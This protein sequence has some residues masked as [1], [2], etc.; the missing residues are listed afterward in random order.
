MEGFVVTF[1]VGGTIFKTTTTT[2]N[3]VP[4]AETTLLCMLLRRRLEEEV[5]FIDKDPVL[6]RWILQW[7][8]HGGR[9]PPAHHTTVGIS[10]EEWSA[11]MDYYGI[12]GEQNVKK[13]PRDEESEIT[14][15]LVKKANQVAEKREEELDK[16]RLEKIRLFAAVIS[17]ML[18]NFNVRATAT[19]YTFASYDQVEYPDSY[20]VE[21]RHD[22]RW[23]THWWKD[24]QDYISNLGYTAKLDI[25]PRKEKYPHFESYRFLPAS[26]LPPLPTG[27]IMCE[28]SISVNK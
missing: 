4:G 14:A 25:Y 23:V 27:H 3:S 21:I 15:S 26:F 24:F 2:L 28:I 8:R 17:Y 6:F 11:E 12:G 16:V 13:R 20:P 7:Y 5:I 18:D 22:F 1:D 9:V 10:E 19:S